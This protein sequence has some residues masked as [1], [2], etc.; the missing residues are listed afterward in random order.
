MRER[1]SRH[2]P[3]ASRSRHPGNVRH[4][5][6]AA[7]SGRDAT[8]NPAHCVTHPHRH[9]KVRCNVTLSATA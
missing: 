2:G 4:G 8:M 9:G 3:S 1:E 5:P 6:D 7:E